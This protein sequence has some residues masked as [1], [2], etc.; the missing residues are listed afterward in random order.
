M[1]VA[2]PLLLLLA[3]C[4]LFGTVRPAGKPVSEAYGGNH[5]L[6]ILDAGS[7]L[8]AQQKVPI[9]STPEVLAVYAPSYADRDVMFG[10]R[11]LFIRVRE[12]EWLADRLRDPDPPAT[13]DAS[14]EAM[15]PLRDVD[16]SRAVVP[17]KR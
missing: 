3:G 14:P 5:E 8:L 12:S 6:R 4:E 9:L 16:W 2:S 11:W 10:E 17:H 1:K 7:P 15:R 13:G